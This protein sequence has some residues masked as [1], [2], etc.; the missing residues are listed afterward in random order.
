MK[1]NLFEMLYLILSKV[2]IWFKRAGDERGLNLL[3]I[4]ILSSE[5]RSTIRTL[6]NEWLSL[7]NSIILCLY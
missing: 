4:A 1:V 5:Y 7:A 6:E 2:F 3:N